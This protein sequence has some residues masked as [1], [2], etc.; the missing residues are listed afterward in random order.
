[1]AIFLL[2]RTKEVLRP[3]YGEWWVVANSGLEE[4]VHSTVDMGGLL[5]GTE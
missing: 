2:M 5:C 3:F 4:D 1:M